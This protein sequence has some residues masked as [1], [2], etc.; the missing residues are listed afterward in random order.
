MSYSRESQHQQVQCTLRDHTASTS[1]KCLLT[2]PSWTFSGP[3]QS[4]PPPSNSPRRLEKRP[5]HLHARTTCLRK[6][7]LITSPRTVT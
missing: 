2:T 3:V 4:A 1:D 7:P 6:H 5:Q